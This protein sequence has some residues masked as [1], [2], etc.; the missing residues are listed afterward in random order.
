MLKGENLREKSDQIH[1]LENLLRDFCHCYPPLSLAAR[2]LKLITQLFLSS[3]ENPQ[4][5]SVSQS[6]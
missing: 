5:S 2:N 4:A 6:A 1:F 3:S